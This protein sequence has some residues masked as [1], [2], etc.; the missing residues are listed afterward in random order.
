MCGKGR[1]HALELALC[2]LRESM[3]VERYRSLPSDTSQVDVVEDVSVEVLFEAEDCSR[4][5]VA[6]CVYVNA[7]IRGLRGVGIRMVLWNNDTIGAV[8][9]RSVL[10][11]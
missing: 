8:L 7:E 6:C 5:L 11:M 9:T 1:S 2:V 10:T 4:H 3:D